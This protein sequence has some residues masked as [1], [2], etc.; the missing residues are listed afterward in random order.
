[1]SF[2]FSLDDDR[3]ADFGEGGREVVNGVDEGSD[4]V[5]DGDAY[6]FDSSLVSAK[7]GEQGEILVGILGVLLVT[8]EVSAEVHLYDDNGAIFHVEGIDVGGW[9]G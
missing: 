7:G 1:M 5:A 2:A 3:W 8:T 6:E 4:S 9:V